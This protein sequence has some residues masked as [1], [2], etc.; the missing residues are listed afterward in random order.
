M[1][2]NTIF[3]MYCEYRR[4]SVGLDFF[5]WGGGG[6]GG[7]HIFGRCSDRMGFEGFSSPASEQ[8]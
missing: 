2:C 4:E 3:E 1:N 8:N 7:G 6:G 5:G